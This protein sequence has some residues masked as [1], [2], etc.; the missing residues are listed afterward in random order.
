MQTAIE[1]AREKAESLLSEVK[2]GLDASGILWSAQSAVA[3]IPDSGTPAARVAR[4]SD[5]A[6]T[7]LPYGDNKGPENHIILESILFNS[8]VPTLCVPEKAK[9]GT[10][11]HIAIAWN[12]SNEALR[13]VR[14]ALPFLMAAETVHIA[15]ID[16]PTHGPDRSDPGGLLAV[17]LARHGVDCDIQ[18][19]ARSGQRVG[20]VL[21]RHV[22]DTAS[23]MLVMGGYGHSR[24][25]EA[26]LGG[27][28]RY[29]L[30]NASVP[31]LM[32]H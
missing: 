22:S 12:E 20:D 30:E 7:S 2:P 13:A 29:M 5:L 3:S 1:Q 32:A 14:S 15:V 16:P 18:V 26:V 4:F 31:V 27:A 19:M 8:G 10:P 23:N 17:M 11:D 25:R 21:L 28:T 9:T 6:V 24:F